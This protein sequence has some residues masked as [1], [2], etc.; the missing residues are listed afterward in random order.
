MAVS[1]PEAA[2]GLLLLYAAPGFGLTA[3]VFPEKVRFRKGAWLSG[4]EVALLSV[5]SSVSL[6]IIFGELLQSIGPGF[7]ASWSDPRLL[8]ANGAVTIVG[9]AAGAVRGAF[10]GRTIPTPVPELERTDPTAWST[11]RTLERLAREERKLARALRGAG[12]GAEERLGLEEEL[13]SVRAERAAL[14]ESR[15][16]EYAA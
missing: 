11:L 12:L 4:L 2:L 8:L 16:G 9:L 5:L 1:A 7:S 14:R 10:G 13:R 3:A 6:T 15:E